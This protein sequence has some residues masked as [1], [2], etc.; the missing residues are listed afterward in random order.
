MSRLPRTLKR[1]RLNYSITRLKHEDFSDRDW[2]INPMKTGERNESL[3]LKNYWSALLRYP[4][5]LVDE[6]G[7]IA[8]SRSD[9]SKLED[10]SAE[11]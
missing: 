5:Q 6:F 9:I 11:E 2:F 8:D 10:L 3:F 4:V 1:R 7:D